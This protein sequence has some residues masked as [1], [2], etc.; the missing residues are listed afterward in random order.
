MLKGSREFAVDKNGYVRMH[1]K[2]SGCVPVASGWKGLVGAVVPVCTRCADQL[3]RRRFD[4]EDSGVTVQT[5]RQS[6]LFIWMFLCA[7]TCSRVRPR[8][9]NA[10]VENVWSTVVA[11]SVDIL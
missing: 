7:A 5:S 6:V 8:H 2:E 1:R 9:I 4:R 3:E 11:S 10:S